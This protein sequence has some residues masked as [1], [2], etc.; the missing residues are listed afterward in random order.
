MIAGEKNKKEFVQL[1]GLLLKLRNILSSFD[2]FEGDASISDRDLQDYQSTYINLYNEFKKIKDA[3]K[4]RI[5]ED[6]IFELELI[7]QIEV[8]IDYILML[9]EQYRES[10]DQ[11]KEVIAKINKIVDSTFRLRSK[12]TL[13]E[14]FINAINIESDES[15]VST[16]VKYVEEQKQ[17]D[18]D[19][20]I[21]EE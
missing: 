17:I 1:F 11:D 21:S 9:I 7:K 16:W 12:K 14:M 8:N 13:I 10:H 15:I 5:N 4:E 19:R 6:I 20:I 3:E 2:Q 18:L